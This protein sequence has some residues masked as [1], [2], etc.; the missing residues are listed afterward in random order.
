M[1]IGFELFSPSASKGSL[2]PA[3]GVTDD[4]SIA[5]VPLAL[6]LMCG[7]GAIATIL[8]MTATVK[9]FR[10]EFGAYI[11]VFVAIIATILS[12]IWS[13]LLARN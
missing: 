5:F 2:I 11:A 13:S 8:G 1:K 10:A 9:D 4:S 3:G 12:P 7:S 6:P